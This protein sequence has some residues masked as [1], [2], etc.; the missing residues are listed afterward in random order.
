VKRGWLRTGMVVLLGS[1]WLLDEASW[2]S[3][4]WAL[5]PDVRIGA[6]GP[7]VL[8]PIAAFSGVWAG[9]AWDGVL[10]HALIVEQVS[11]TGDTS[12]ISSWGD[13][14]DWQMARGHS[15]RPTTRS[16][17]WPERGA[18]AEAGRHVVSASREALAGCTP[19]FRRHVLEVL[20]QPSRRVL[21]EYNFAGVL[22]LNSFAESAPRV[23]TVRDSGSAW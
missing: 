22:D 12:V 8:A 6:P 15:G 18:G 2:V 4:P 23:M 21:Q 16:R 13:A 7:E 17:R 9:G 20:R 11:A 3:A 19:A 14:P 10:P 5:P 1:V